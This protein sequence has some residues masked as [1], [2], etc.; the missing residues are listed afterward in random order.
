MEPQGDS[1]IAAFR[2][3]LASDPA[4]AELVAH[5]PVGVAAAAGLSE[6]DAA[7]VVSAVSRTAR[8]AENFALTQ[9]AREAVGANGGSAFASTPTG[10]L[11]RLGE[12]ALSTAQMCA[13]RS[14]DELRLWGD[15]DEWRDRIAALRHWNAEWPE[16]AAT[17]LA[18]RQKADGTETQRAISDALANLKRLAAITSA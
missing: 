2:A 8:S 16:V 7:L 18:T 1:P 5:D 10:D 11:I 6:E 9:Q 12:A 3:R 4:F 14:D 13:D 17:E 15:V